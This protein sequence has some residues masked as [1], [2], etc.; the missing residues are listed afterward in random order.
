MG[1]QQNNTE[2]MQDVSTNVSTLLQS[3]MSLDDIAREFLDSKPTAMSDSSG[4]AKDAAGNATYHKGDSS[5]QE[6][7]PEQLGFFHPVNFD[8]EHETIPLPPARYPQL[9]AGD[10]PY[11]RMRELFPDEPLSIADIVTTNE[12]AARI[13]T[14]GI[15]CHLHLSGTKEGSPQRKREE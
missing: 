14:S 12:S 13:P 1:L 3:P 2:S 15:R 10:K 5:S 11:H 6:R 7:S 8:E 4:R 9:L